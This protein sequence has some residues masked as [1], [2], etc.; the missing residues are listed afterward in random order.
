VCNAPVFFY[1]NAAG[2]RVYFD[3]L[4]PPWPKHPCTDNGPQRITSVEAMN[5]A[6]T[7]RPIGQVK[8]LLAAAERA[9]LNKP[10]K[11]G[12]K[13]RPDWSLA[14]V[15]ASRRLGKEN[16]IEA[17]HLDVAMGGLFSFSCFSN[18]EFLSPGDFVSIQ[19]NQVSCVDRESL[20][21]VFFKFGET[22]ELDKKHEPIETKNS[23]LPLVR[24]KASLKHTRLIK[25]EQLD[26]PARAKNKPS[27]EREKSG[28]FRKSKFDMQQSEMVH[29]DS[30]M[31]TFEELFRV[32]E[33]VVKRLAREGTRKPK[34]VAPRL[35]SLGHRTA[36]GSKW[37]SR[38][39]YFLLALV[40]NKTIPEETQRNKT[41]R[42]QKVASKPTPQK[43]ISKSLTDPLTKENIAERL[44]SLGKVSIVKKKIE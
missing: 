26:N 23:V 44:T 25:R 13:D 19:A 33:P 16:Q 2:S 37:T 5:G 42:N 21:P 10:V 12:Q 14:F 34:D 30:G 38:L 41:H 11:S 40:F 4:G 22:V 20:M 35:N 27:R 24:T 6:P 36:A 29:F 31:V 15:H 39:V 18:R 17:E 28:A 8:E 3:D 32:L 9:G 1:A 43:Q 7:S